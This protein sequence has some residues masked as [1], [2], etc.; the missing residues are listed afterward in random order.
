M[1][2]KSTR[3]CSEKQ[4][5]VRFDDDFS[6]FVVKA[7]S[8]YECARA[9]HLLK[10]TG[11]TS[12]REFLDDK[13][14][15]EQEQLAEELALFRKGSAKAD[16][17]AA[18]DSLIVDWKAVDFETNEPIEFSRQNVINLLLSDDELSHL[19]DEA[20]LAAFN[21]S[22]FWQKAIEEAKEQIKK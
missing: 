8:N 19:V 17:L 4:F 22:N 6:L 3:R 5:E 21:E 16:R 12:E 7:G 1:K 13:R 9:K 15:N 11:Y 20:A 18:V 10:I 2:V 14:M